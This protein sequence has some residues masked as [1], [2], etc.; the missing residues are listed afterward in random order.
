MKKYFII[1]IVTLFFASFT[2]YGQAEDP[3]KVFK[4]SVKPEKLDEYM[5]ERGWK[6]REGGADEDGEAYQLYRKKS[7]GGGFVYIASFENK[8]VHYQKFDSDKHDYSVIITYD[9]FVNTPEGKTH[10][11]SSMENPN[12]FIKNMAFLDHENNKN[13]N[14]FYGVV[15]AHADNRRDHD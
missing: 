5:K 2:S 12:T 7:Y 13:E 14:K 6:K 9:D 8:F 4:L 10:D 11:N 15:P 3:E 1:T